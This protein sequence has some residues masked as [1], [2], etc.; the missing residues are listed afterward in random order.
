MK[1]S[2][3]IRF[4]RPSFYKD[5]GARKFSKSTK[6]GD[7]DDENEDSNV[8]DDMNDDNNDESELQIDEGVTDTPEIM[9]KNR[10]S[11]RKA[12]SGGGKLM[13]KIN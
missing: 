7:E 1:G 8:E 3:K 9:K 10:R 13:T 11:S 12:K 5:L 4:S 2:I 6:T